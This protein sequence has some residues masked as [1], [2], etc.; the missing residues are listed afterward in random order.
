[1]S[2]DP[3]MRNDDPFANLSGDD[4]IAYNNIRISRENGWV[5]ATWVPAGFCGR[6]INNGTD[7]TQTMRDAIAMAKSFSL[8]ERLK[9]ENDD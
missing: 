5:I 2:Y 9:K 7:E 6:L 8:V 3:I 4:L 1:M